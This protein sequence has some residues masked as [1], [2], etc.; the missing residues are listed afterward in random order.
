MRPA[1]GKSFGIL[2]GCLGLLLLQGR[3][4][5]AARPLQPTSGPATR[6]PV[7]TWRAG[8]APAAGSVVAATDIDL[9]PDGTV[10]VLDRLLARAQRFDGA[11]KALTVY[12]QVGTPGA[13]RRPLGLAVD[14]G[15]ARVYVADTG[16]RRLAVFGLDGAFQTGWGGFSE[17]EA[18]T[19]GLDGRV[20]VYDRGVH[21]I[22]VRRPDGGDEGVFPVQV[23][24]ARLVE[25]PRGISTAP[26][27]SIF[28]A[29]EAPVANGPNILYEFSAAGLV[30]PPRTQLPWQ[31]RDFGFAASGQLLLLDGTGQRLVTQLDRRSGATLAS[32]VEPG[33]VAMAAGSDGT[34]QLLYKA[35][36]GRPTRLT[37]VSV[38]GNTVSTLGTQPFPAVRRGWFDHPVRVE[39]VPGGGALVLDTLGRLQ[40]FTAGGEA[41]GQFSAPGLQEATLHPSGKRLFIVRVHTPSPDEPDDPDGAAPGMRR[42]RVEARDLPDGLLS[43]ADNEAPSTPAWLVDW[44]EPLNAATF[45]QIEALAYHPPTDRLLALDSGHRRLLQWTAY[46]RPLPDIALPDPGASVPGY[47]DMAVSPS[48]KV[49]LLNSGAHLAYGLATLDGGLPEDSFDLGVAAY[50][51]AVTPD[52][53]LVALSGHRTVHVVGREGGPAQALRLP[54]EGDAGEASD[55]AVDGSGR[56][57]VADFDPRAVHVFGSG[58]L[59]LP[60]LWRP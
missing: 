56:I 59:F 14:S 10:V 36:G 29:A 26:S 15:I 45:T 12:G 58:S 22:K 47:T 19:V 48:G 20:Y 2:L 7:I 6:P 8:A 50:R 28:F 11:G 38:S 4:Q 9:A 16:N 37:R 49:Y 34:V 51:L 1:L 33:A 43:G 23:A 13:L 18:V 27:G 52:Q 24:Q 40:H 30:V 25:L 32:P 54:S 31:I 55:V 5:A 3:H 17:P 46:G 53:Q 42:Y 44:S 35:T 39:A 60:I 57:Y 41:L 21:G